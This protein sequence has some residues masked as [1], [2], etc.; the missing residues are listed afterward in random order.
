MKIEDDKRRRLHSVK[1]DA[2][3]KVEDEGRVK[4]LKEQEVM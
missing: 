2:D 4:Q 3:R 1:R